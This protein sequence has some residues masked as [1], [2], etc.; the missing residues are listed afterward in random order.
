MIIVFT[1][2]QSPAALLYHHLTLHLLSCL[3]PLIE[4]LQSL[5]GRLVFRKKPCCVH[6]SPVFHSYRP[7]MITSVTLAPSYYYPWLQSP[8]ENNRSCCHGS[9][10]RRWCWSKCEQVEQERLKI[11]LVWIQM[12]LARWGRGIFLWHLHKAKH[13][14]WTREGDDNKTHQTNKDSVISGYLKDLMLAGWRGLLT[15]ADISNNRSVS[16]YYWRLILMLI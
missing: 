9:T 7:L 1:T 3:R 6:V 4:R 8:A 15:L 2:A 10:K 5:N 11:E 13:K 16:C 12:S 14:F